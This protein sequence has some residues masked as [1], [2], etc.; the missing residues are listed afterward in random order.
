VRF[1]SASCFCVVGGLDSEIQVAFVGSVALD[2]SDPAWTGLPKVKS[3]VEKVVV[4]SALLTGLGDPAARPEKAACSDCQKAHSSLE[5]AK[6]PEERDLS[7]R[8]PPWVVLVTS[9][10]AFLQVASYSELEA[11]VLSGLWLKAARHS[12]HFEALLFAV[13][14]EKTDLANSAIC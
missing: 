13:A 14:R 4:D 6:G 3:R 12:L 9:P 8:W 1:V 11:A 7:E 10:L 5:S 2:H